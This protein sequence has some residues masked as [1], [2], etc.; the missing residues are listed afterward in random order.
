MFRC[1]FE[2]LFLSFPGLPKEL[3]FIIRAEQSK[4]KNTQACHTVNRPHLFPQWDE[5]RLEDFAS[6]FNF[7][8]VEDYDEHGRTIFVLLFEAVKYSWLAADIALHA[9]HSTS[10]KM[11]GCYHKALR[12]RITSGP[13][14]GKLAI[15]ILVQDSDAMLMQKDIVK[16]LIDNEYYTVLDFVETCWVRH[17]NDWK[18]Y[19]F[20]PF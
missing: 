8:N 13:L 6:W 19:C 17:F 18:V 9:F 16:E 20:S 11:S 15:N 14:K 3:G 12:Q 1:L 10:P 4:L 2:F 7:R 5:R